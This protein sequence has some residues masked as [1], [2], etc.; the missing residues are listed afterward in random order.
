MAGSARRR[1]G[2]DAGKRDDRDES[3]ITLVRLGVHKNL[4]DHPAILERHDQ[5]LC[6][7]NETLRAIAGRLGVDAGIQMAPIDMASV[8]ED[9]FDANIID[10]AEAE[11]S[12]DPYSELGALDG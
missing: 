9:L 4:G 11:G 5:L 3:R 10:N 6:S 7:I 12:D 1:N 2:G 8:L